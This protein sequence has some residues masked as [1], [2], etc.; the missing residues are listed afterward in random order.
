MFEPIRAAR[1]GHRS[2][3]SGPAC[4]LCYG[5][6]SVLAAVA[7]AVEHY[8]KRAPRASRRRGSGGRAPRRCERSGTTDTAPGASAR[9]RGS[10]AESAAARRRPPQRERLAVWS[11]CTTLK[12]RRATADVAVLAAG[13]GSRRARRCRREHGFCV[14]HCCRW[15]QL[16]RRGRDVTLAIHGAGPADV[17]GCCDSCGWSYRRATAG[18]VVLAAG[19][20][21]RQARRRRR[22]HG[23][24]VGHCC[25]S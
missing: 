8:A 12:S 1:S 20:G 2:P 25:R 10:G 24:C 17:R 21:A 14:G 23:C 6:C 4:W 18:V 7:G 9:H 22:E 3:G 11:M 16:E 5:S 19:G 13:G 15:R